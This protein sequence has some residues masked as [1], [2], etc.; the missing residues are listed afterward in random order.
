MITDEDFLRI[1]AD[2]RRASL[3]FDNDEDLS[4][5]RELALEYYKGEMSDVVTLKNRSQVVSTDVADAVETILP[6]LVE[7][8]TGDEIASFNP[9]GEEDEE[10][11]AQET[12]YLNHVVFSENDGFM[13]LYTM[14]K[15]ALITKTGVLKFWW[16]DYENVE[17]DEFTG[18]TTEE[19]LYAQQFGEIVKAEQDEAG[20]WSFTLRRVDKG[21]CAKIEAVPPEDF[22]VG[23]DTVS[24]RNATYAAHRSRPRAQQL[25][26][27]GYDAKLIEGLPA[28]GEV[29]NSLQQARDTAGEHD[30]QYGYTNPMRLVEIVDHYIRIDAD[31]DGKSELWRV[32]TGGNES[33]LIEKEQVEVM[34]FAA[35]TPFVVTHRFYGLSVADRLMEVQRIKTALTR[36]AL[37]AGY[38]SLNQRM[39]VAADRAN[40]FTIPDLLRNEPGVPIRSRTGDAV[41]PVSA[42]GLNFDPYAALEYFSTVSESRTGIVRNAQGL[43]PDTLHD[44]AKGAQALMSAAQKRVRMIARLFAETGVKDLFLG[45][46]TLIRK[47]ATKAQKVRLRNKWTEIDPTSWGA[48]KDMTIEIGVGAGGK[49]QEALMLREGL[50]ALM[51]VVQLQGGVSGPF[52]TPENAHAYLKRFFER[53]LGFKNADPFIS[54]PGEAQPQEPPPDPKMVEVQQKMQLEQAKLEADITLKREQ[55]QA[56]IQL[57]R[58]QMAIEAQLKAVEANTRMNMAQSLSPVRMGG[59]VG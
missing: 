26:D 35:V 41:R 39:E 45:L 53:G 37:D 1:V 29:D 33:V 7:I 57:K 34:P 49:E 25:I 32:V 20:L 15:D 55:M 8:F 51:Q 30:E 47:H 38:F 5:A 17:E 14:F 22:T 21:G 56:E 54:D 19:A 42:G 46:H 9:T 2:E 44:T 59:D 50:A 28:Y 13:C 58:E 27:Q 31:G 23:R 36:M 4:D 24:L 10:A 43:N 18:K 6:D 48:R 16:E 12:D 3:G 52:V 11:A 40:Q